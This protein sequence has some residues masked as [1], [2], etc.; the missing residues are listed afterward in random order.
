M[1]QALP[2]A[3]AA[4]LLLAACGKF[5]T[6][7]PGTDAG[8]DLP[9]T[10]PAAPDC[11]DG[12][13]PARG[14]WVRCAAGSGAA[15]AIANAVATDSAGNIY[16]TGGFTQTIHIGGATLTAKGFADILLA[17]YDATGKFQW[18]RQFGGGT[19]T[20][21]EEKGTAVAVAPD[22][23]IFLAGTFIGVVDF[24]GGYVLQGTPNGFLVKLNPAG[25]TIWARQG[26]D[27]ANAL[28][29]DASGN[30]Y[31]TGKGLG[32]SRTATDPVLG[33]LVKFDPSGALLWELTQQFSEGVA[34]TLDADGNPVL[35]GKAAYTDLFGLPPDDSFSA[36][37]SAKVSAAGKV[38]W[39][40][41]YELQAT[42]V[43][44]VQVLATN[45]VTVFAL[46]A[47]AAGTVVDLG[48]GLTVTTR[49]NE[50]TYVLTYGADGLAKSA[51]P[52]ATL[53][54]SHFLVT[55]D[56]DLVSGGGCRLQAVL[57]ATTT[58]TCP[59]GNSAYVARHDPAGKVRWVAQ[60]TPET[61]LGALRLDAAG[62]IVAVGHYYRDRLGKS[63]TI[64]GVPLPDLTF[65]SNPGWFVWKR[66]AGP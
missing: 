55:K 26:G 51:V 66:P 65:G 8:A 53:Q 19:K 49:A 35:V 56:L 25:E 40:K 62:N 44:G 23:S 15:T 10:G 34:L 16:V 61:S 47:Q 18:A 46:L 43:L 31:L 59:D 60:A 36:N 3:L 39:A 2:R 63:P 58:I 12:V 7:A 5:T 4:A 21:E 1:T 64:D 37:F 11:L 57:D 32:W 28:A 13:G 14:P 33:P 54:S 22:G 20:D 48:D 30:C 29:I 52:L 6:P 17:K 9:D 41:P 24:G 42:A 38:L 45:Q 50:R 27:W